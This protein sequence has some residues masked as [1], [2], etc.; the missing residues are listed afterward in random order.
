[1]GMV[2]PQSG[3]FF[4]QRTENAAI[5][6]V[7]SYNKSCTWK[8]DRGAGKTKPNDDWLPRRYCEALTRIMHEFIYCEASDGYSLTT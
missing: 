3:D 7:F 1:M 2:L 6:T 8:R 5:P 4:R